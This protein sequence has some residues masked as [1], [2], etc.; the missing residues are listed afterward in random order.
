MKKNNKDELR[1]TTF[2]G[3]ESFGPLLYQSRDV[4]APRLRSLETLR[5]EQPF[6]EVR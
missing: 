3:E 6:G 1:K 5:E 4:V 2:M